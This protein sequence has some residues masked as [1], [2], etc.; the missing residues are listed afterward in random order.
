MA[1]L[2]N[3]IP[4]WTDWVLAS[5]AAIVVF[6]VNIT[7]SGDPLSGLG[8]SSDPISA[9]ITDGARTTF[10]GAL[11]LGALTLTAAGLIVMSSRR[12]RVLGGLLVRTY[13]GVSLA[14]F[15]GLLLDYRDGPVRTVQ[16][17]VY[18]M[19]FLGIVR[20][21]RMAASAVDDHDKTQDQAG[22]DQ[23]PAGRAS[24]AST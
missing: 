5:I 14:G 6:N 7:T 20:L 1:S 22:F 3:R 24:R 2:W 4:I 19:L 23:A 21:A 17:F 12:D 11:A 18:L 8:R 13:A 10:Y 9:G 16:L 15:L